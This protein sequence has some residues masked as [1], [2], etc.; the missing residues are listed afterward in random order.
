MVRVDIVQPNERVVLE[1][2]H[3]SGSRVAQ[4]YDW[5]PHLVRRRLCFGFPSVFCFLR[6]QVRYRQHQQSCNPREQ[7]YFSTWD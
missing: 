3:H 5:N 7:E 6:P 4:G 2:G 1:G